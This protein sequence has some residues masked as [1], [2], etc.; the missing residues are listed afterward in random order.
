MNKDT[1]NRE[2]MND[3]Y[4]QPLYKGTIIQLSV[5]TNV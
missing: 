5:T 4:S 2:T 1:F 3:S